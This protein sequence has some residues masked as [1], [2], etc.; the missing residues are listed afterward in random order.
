MKML[1]FL[2]IFA[3][4]CAHDPTQ[5]TCRSFS[6]KSKTTALPMVTKTETF[7]VVYPCGI[8][9]VKNTLERL[10]PVR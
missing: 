3:S 9:Q 6:S 8:R 5:L 4:S 2:L 1:L 10:G 7:E